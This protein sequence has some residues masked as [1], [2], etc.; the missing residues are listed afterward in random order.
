VVAL[1]FAG[2]VIAA[3]YLALSGM[4]TGFSVVPRVSTPDEI[5][6]RATLYSAAFIVGTAAPIV[7]I[8]ATFYTRQYVLRW[9]FGGVLAITLLIGAQ[10][11]IDGVMEDWRRPPPTLRVPTCQE[12]SGGDNR[13][14]GG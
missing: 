3:P 1:L 4:F 12:H 10:A 6:A 13:C 9:L 7:G 8:A 5:S 2:T 14:L 11:W